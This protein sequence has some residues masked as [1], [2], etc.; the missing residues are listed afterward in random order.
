MDSLPLALLLGLVSCQ[1][2]G[3]RPG[4]PA[5]QDSGSSPPWPGTGSY[6]GPIPIPDLDPADTAP[7]SCTFEP[8][9]PK[10]YEGAASCTPLESIDWIT[11]QDGELSASELGGSSLSTPVVTLGPTG[12]TLVFLQLREIDDEGRGS[13]L[14]WDPGT[15]RVEVSISTGTSCRGGTPVFRGSQPGCTLVG[16]LSNV[17]E[18][19]YVFLDLASGTGTRGDQADLSSGAIVADLQHDGVPEVLSGSFQYSSDGVISTAYEDLE[20]TMTPMVFDSDGDARLEITNAAGWWD[21][22][23]GSGRSWGAFAQGERPRAWF[24][25]GVVETD[26]GVVLAGH[27]GE[28]H[29]VADRSGQALWWVPENNRDRANNTFAYPSIGDIDGDGQPELVADLY[30]TTTI[31]RSMDGAILWQRETSIGAHYTN[32]NAMADLDADG[33]YEII[34]WGEL[35]LWILDGHDGAVLAR[36]E[37]GYNHSWTRAPLIADVDADGS[38][39]IVVVGDRVGEDS[40]RARLF[41]LGPATGRWARTRPVWHQISYDVTSVRDDGTIP[42]FPRAN[43][44][45]YNSWRAQP[46]HD[47]DHPDLEIEVLETC[48]DEQAGTVSVQV[49]VHNRGSQDAPAGAVVRLMSWLEGSGV[50]L[51]EIAASTLTDPIPSMSSSAGVVFEV[52]V[53]D[54]AT[55]QVLQ[56]DGAHDDECDLVNDRVDVWEE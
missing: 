33:D 52:P 21:A 3:L 19:T 51:Q 36:W 17:G 28:S 35:G 15:G 39:E 32:Q 7:P 20:Y 18:S 14:G 6:Q 47:G 50:G 41:V 34:V 42:A 53:E 49:V 10:P 46:A 11:I 23:D 13:F 38:A 25:A 1:D 45:T 26:S 2:Y 37:D 48:R 5:P 30:G 24:M 27:N 31:A 55:R 43:F 22:N 40:D 4:R 56:V 12:S 44:D 9:Q 16:T 29:F 54:W 8:I